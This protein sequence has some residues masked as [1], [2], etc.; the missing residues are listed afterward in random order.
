M[1]APTEPNNSKTAPPNEL[2]LAILE[3]TI[4]L[5]EAAHSLSSLTQK[6]ERAQKPASLRRG[7]S[8][9]EAA[10]YVGISGTK[11]GQL[12]QEKRMPEPKKIDGRNV[13]DVYALDAFF[14]ALGPVEDAGAQK[15]PWN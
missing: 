4:G 13:W 6:T 7:L 14:D 1:N 9:N 5:K 11:F 8:R 2:S 12:V 10:E 15:N 3:A